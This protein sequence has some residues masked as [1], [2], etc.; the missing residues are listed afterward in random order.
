[1]KIGILT[2]TYSNYGTLLQAY[3]LQN[4]LKGE[5][6]IVQLINYTPKNENVI[7]YNKY[8][9]SNFMKRIK[10]KIILIDENKK[11][12]KLNDFF[13]KGMIK[14]E[15]LFKEFIKENLPL[16]KNYTIEELSCLNNK[17]DV[18]IVGSDQ[19]WSPKY[20]DGTFF[21][22]FLNDNS[23]KISYAPSFGVSKLDDKVQNLIRPWLESFDYISVRENAGQKIIKDT[24]GKDVP[25][26]LD[27][28]LLYD[29]YGWN[30]IIREESMNKNKKYILCYFLSNNEYYWKIVR[31]LEEKLGLNVIVI[32]NKSLDFNNKYEKEIE[33]DPFKFVSLI[34]NSDYVLTDS[35]HGTIFAINYH[36]DFLTLARFSDKKKESENSRLKSILSYLK[37]QDR[38]I[39]EEES[40]QCNLHVGDEKYSEVEK[41][42]DN[43]RK[44]SKDFILE[45]L[46]TI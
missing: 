24:I 15:N 22:N 29:M 32:P 14:R 40:I 7:K 2:W 28:T 41:R 30:D 19:I 16:T 25:V 31:M 10:N 5:G 43:R 9:I 11:M 4:Y 18:F 27:P 33:V 17:F 44:E 35:F 6:H 39:T 34:K 12:E 37:L 42:L 8:N 13:K 3:A 46:K 45:S 38:F 1:M 26:V 23:R 21:L 36:K 20:L